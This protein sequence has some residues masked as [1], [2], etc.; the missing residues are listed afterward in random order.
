MQIP[1]CLFV[2]CAVVSC[3]LPLSAK[4]DDSQAQA[5]ARAALQQ[6]LGESQPQPAQVQAQTSEPAATSH[7]MPPAM[8]PAKANPPAGAEIDSATVAKAR[9]AMHSK[10]V[11]LQGQP[12]QV[13]PSTPPAKA[14]ET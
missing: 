5:K 1:K 3:I 8:A 12:A 11:E 7:S 14:I 2:V 4:A 9:E 6:S 10:M 13:A